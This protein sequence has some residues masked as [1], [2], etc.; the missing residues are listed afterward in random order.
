MGQ[1]EKMHFSLYGYGVKSLNLKHN[2]KYIFVWNPAHFIHV[3]VTD[4]KRMV[5]I[6]FYTAT[7]CAHNLCSIVFCMP[8]DYNLVIDIL[9]NDAK[10]HS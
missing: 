6:A 5:K 1:S 4:L 8:G 10:C 7:D 9:Y 3:R 2:Y